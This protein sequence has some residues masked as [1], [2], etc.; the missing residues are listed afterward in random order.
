VI[1]KAEVSGGKRPLLF[2][3]SGPSGVGKDA[4]LAQMKEWGRPM[5]FTVTAT[6]RKR[7]DA[8]RNRVDY[9]FVSVKK[10]KE[11]I[12]CGEMLEWAEVYGNFYGVPRGEVKQALERG[13]DVMIKVDVQGAATIKRVV[14]GAVLI[15]LEAPSLAVLEERLRNRRSDSDGDIERRIRTASAEMKKIKIFDY[16]VVN[17]DVGQAT[18]DVKSIITAEKCRAKPR[19]VKL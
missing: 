6:T 18:A 7:R 2:V 16:M 4:V 9:H 13:E 1:L 12:E 19:K 11:M 5:H 10:F 3:I 14:P 17:T 15:F 8:E